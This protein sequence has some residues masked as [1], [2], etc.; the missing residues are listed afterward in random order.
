M[1]AILFVH[2]GVA[3]YLHYPI[4][5]L[6]GVL[7]NVNEISRDSLDDMFTMAIVKTKL[8]VYFGGYCFQLRCWWI[9]LCLNLLM[10]N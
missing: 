8:F 9:N 3:F 10:L 5:L 6:L 4:F 2:V 7:H 1:F